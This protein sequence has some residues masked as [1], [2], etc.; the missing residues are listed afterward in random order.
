MARK[1]KGDQGTRRYVT[2]TLDEQE[3]LE[4]DQYQAAWGLD[5]RT[6]V[7]RALIAGGKS[8]VPI[9]SMEM[10]LLK[11]VLAE[12]RRLLF[13]RVAHDLDETSRLLRGPQ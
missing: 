3:V 2:L 7:A 12:F 13:E 6:A 1:P 11:Q 4:F 8:A 9:V 5:N 10:E